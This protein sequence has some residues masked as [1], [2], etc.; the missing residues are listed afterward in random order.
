MTL[1]LHTIKKSKTAIKK[2]KR[3][4]RGN[5]S[6]TGTYSGKGLK[7]QKARSGV[8]DLKKLGMRQVLLRTPKKRG[9]TSLKAKA[10]IVN[11]SSLNKVFKENDDVNPKV[12]LEKG[13]IDNGSVK[14]KILGNGELKVGGLKFSDLLLSESAKAK[15]EKSKGKIK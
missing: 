13:L 3:I 7:G 2:R 10:Q 5:A 15:I 9:F 14:V 11:L 4:G 6:G 1:S 8:S 12:L